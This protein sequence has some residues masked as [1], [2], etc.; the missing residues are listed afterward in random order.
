M[1]NTKPMYHRINI[2]NNKIIIINNNSK[3][4]NNLMKQITSKDLKNVKSKKK[5]NLTLLTRNYINFLKIKLI[6]I[7]E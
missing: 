4:K 7:L 6:F 3:S 1:N 2:V 5:N